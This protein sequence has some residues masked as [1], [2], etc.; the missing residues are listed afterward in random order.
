MKNHHLLAS[1]ANQ[2]IGREIFTP[3]D[4][5]LTVRDERNNVVAQWF[6]E[7]K[8]YSVT[9]VV[10]DVTAYAIHEAATLLT[11]NQ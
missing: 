7:L 5:D 9:T 4:C 1:I 8:L 6:P 10:G 3:N 11:E 2:K